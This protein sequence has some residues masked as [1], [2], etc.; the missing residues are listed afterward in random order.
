MESRFI[1]I[2]L[3]P[4]QYG[5]PAMAAIW[6]L[7]RA[8]CK[9]VFHNPALLNTAMDRQF[10]VSYLNY[11]ANIDAGALAYA[12]SLDP[13]RQW[14]VGI[15]YMNYGTM[16]WVTPENIVLGE[17]T[18]N[19]LA[20]TGTYAWTLSSRWRAGGTI[21]LLYSVLDEY[22]S[23]AAVVDLGVYYADPNQLLSGGFTINHLGSQFVSYEEKYEFMPWDIKIGLSKRLAHAPFR[24]NITVQ[25]LSPSGF[26][27]GINT[28]STSESLST[29]KNS[30]NEELFRHVLM[31]VD[32]LPSDQFMLCV[33]YNYRRISDLGIEQ[34]TSFGGFTAGLMLHVKGMSVGASYARYHVGGNSWQFSLSTSTSAFGL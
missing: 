14:M 6:F 9:L 32:F 25:G 7:L 21:G 28:D 13:S 31:G 20:L 30:W 33:G 19:D 24:F 11:L 1:R 18:A 3:F 5:Q 27:R 8:R 29:E 4:F 15:R 34:R 2:W 22:T 17:T 23:L 10:S 16:K 26:T 12:R